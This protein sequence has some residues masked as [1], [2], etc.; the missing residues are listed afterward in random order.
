MQLLNLPQELIVQILYELPPSDLRACQLTNKYLSTIIRESVVLQY[1]LTLTMAKPEDNPCSSLSTS[2]NL[3]SL[4]F[5]EEAWAFL[6]PDF[7]TSVLV[8]RNQSG[9]YDLTGGV[10]L[11]SDMERTG[12]RYLKLPGMEG[13]DPTWK[14]VNTGK[15]IVDIGLCI[16]EHDLMAIVT[17]H[18]KGFCT[19]RQGR[20]GLPTTFDIE[21]DLL[22]L[23]TKKP[24]RQVQKNPI[25]VM[26][27][28]WEKPAAGI[29]IFGK[30]LILI[31]CY[32]NANRP[33]DRI[34]TYEP[35]MLH[36]EATQVSYSSTKVEGQEHQLNA[37]RQRHEH[38]HE[39]Q[40]DH[41]DLGPLVWRKREFKTRERIPF[42]GGIGG[43]EMCVD[44][45]DEEGHQV[46]GNGNGN[47]HRRHYGN[48]KKLVMPV[49]SLKTTPTFAFAFPQSK[50]N[51]ATKKG[52]ERAVDGDV[53]MLGV[54]T[55]SE[56]RRGRSTLPSNHLKKSQ[57]PLRKVVIP[58]SPL[59]N[60]RTEST[61]DPRPPDPPSTGAESE[62]RMPPK[63]RKKWMHREVEAMKESS[64]SPGSGR[65]ENGVGSPGGDGL[66][67]G[68]DGGG[69]GT[70]VGLGIRVESNCVVTPGWGRNSDASAAHAGLS[71]S[72]NSLLR[73]CFAS[74]TIS[75][76]A[77]T[78]SNAIHLRNVAISWHLDRL[79]VAPNILRQPLSPE[80]GD[81]LPIPTPDL[82]VS[83]VAEG[84]IYNLEPAAPHQ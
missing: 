29:E 78:I 62:G 44:R 52:K 69:A 39:Q 17:S 48:G 42:S 25:Y 34:F 3:R 51:S 58:G 56:E 28:P 40:R 43:M 18:T 70:K 31:L 23:S 36:I 24:H 35:F 72:D 84:A 5:T 11:L 38:E 20:A 7:T 13:E 12:L 68:F 80:S 27:L 57:S 33:D 37:Q 9:V 2:E 49:Q 79:Y 19:A 59:P 61:W 16:Y 75:L 71:R 83:A 60:S 67:L 66:E 55:D 64:G 6:R 10:Y 30:H 74:I 45:A 63:M 76:A 21:V 65:S 81:P 32:N 14:D 54:E 15:M 41:I 8:T 47:G 46:N 1:N 50:P 4:H 53:E 22:E 82:S 73:A 26:N 77:N